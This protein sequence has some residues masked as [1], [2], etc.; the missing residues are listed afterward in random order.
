MVA[1]VYLNGESG[2]ADLQ[3][4]RD[5]VIEPATYAIRLQNSKSEIR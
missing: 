3:K 5:G 4:D 1:V 2:F